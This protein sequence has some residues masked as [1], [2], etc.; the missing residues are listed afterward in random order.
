[1]KRIVQTIRSFNWR[2]WLVLA[3]TLFI[4][5]LY[6]TLRLSLLGN[7]PDAWGVNIASQ[8]GWVNLLYEILQE[9][10]I[11]PLYFL[12]GK[13]SGSKEELE[14][15]AK[16]GFLFSGGAYLLLS[17]L[18]VLFARPLCVG[19][20]SDPATLEATVS[21]IRWES[22]ASAIGILSQFILVLL[23]TMERERYMYLLLFVRTALTMLL[24]T[25]FLSELPCS[26][27][28]GVNGIAYSN[29]LVNAFCV[30]AALG[31]LK[32]EGF[33]LFRRGKLD[34]TW[35]REYGRIGLYWG[36]SPLFGTSPS[37]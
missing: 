22:L 16:A 37:C 3:V 5:A 14:K 9:G 7:L 8:L 24:D 30:A 36:W 28:L 15:N 31:F 32:K 2:L 12:L 4:P 1:M 11:L 27:R 26:L 21:Y 25:L 18:I 20:A 17:L 10:L 19:M 33:R 13:A 23:V 29:I 35:L 34:T 6:Q